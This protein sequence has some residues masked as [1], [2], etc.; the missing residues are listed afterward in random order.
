M[1]QSQREELHYKWIG[2]DELKECF[3]LSLWNDSYSSIFVLP[4]QI[5]WA[6]NEMQIKGSPKSFS[7]YAWER[8]YTN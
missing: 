4:D 1:W 5:E 2:D 6:N 8:T 3:V 7:I